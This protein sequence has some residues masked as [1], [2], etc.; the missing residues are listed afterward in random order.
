MFHKRTSTTT[1]AAP[2]ASPAA[3]GGS[4][5]ARI[6]LTLFGAV[7]LIVSAFLEWVTKNSVSADR[8]SLRVLYKKTFGGNHDFLVT[9]GFL[10]VVLGALA[11]IGLAPRSGW[12]TR[13]AGALAIVAILLFGIEV[14]RTNLLEIPDDLGVGVYVAAVSAL[15]TVIGGFLGTRVRV[16]APAAPATTTTVA[17][18]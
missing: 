4:L 5:A 11:I 1:P 6:I 7:G 18:P 3:G 2:A 9:V 17:E 12:L 8:L 13:L 16:V 14:W 15:L 10:M